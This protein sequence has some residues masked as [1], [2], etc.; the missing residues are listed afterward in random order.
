MHVCDSLFGAGREVIQEIGGAAVR[1]DYSASVRPHCADE[2]GPWQGLTLPIHR[3]VHF[4][5]LAV[6]AEDF[7]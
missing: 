7:A 3:H 4:S 2:A 6:H 1:V 5:K